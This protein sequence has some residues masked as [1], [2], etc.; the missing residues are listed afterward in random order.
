MATET[1][2]NSIVEAL[3]SWKGPP[4]AIRGDDAEKL[5][6]EFVQ[7]F[8]ISA[9]PKLPLEDYALGQDKLDTVSY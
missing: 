1:A 9:W 2:R 7:R 8:P 3:A 4:A 6:A 5:R